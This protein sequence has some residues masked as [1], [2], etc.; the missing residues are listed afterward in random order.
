M[1]FFYRE[2]FTLPSQGELKGMSFILNT[3]SIYI[4]AHMYILFF[5]RASVQSLKLRVNGKIIEQ[6]EKGI[7]CCSRV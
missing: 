7:F 3:S 5:I 1:V 4:A 2:D 6:F